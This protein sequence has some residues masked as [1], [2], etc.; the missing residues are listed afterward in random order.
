MNQMDTKRRAAIVAALVEGFG[1]RSTC[2]M[3]STSKGAALKLVADLGAACANYHDREVRGIACNFL[4]IDE[5]WAF[6]YAKSKN[7]PASK[8]DEFGYG[9]V[10][11]WTAIDAETKLI[12]SWL[13]GL[14][15]GGYATELMQDLAGRLVNRP[16]IT[17]DGLASYPA[18]IEEAFGQ[19]VDYAQLQKIYGPNP[20]GP[21]RRYSPA[22]C[23]GARVEVISGDPA[24]DQ[25]S[26]SYVERS[27]LSIR[28]G[29]RRFTRLTNG[30]SKKVEN[31]C[32]ALAIYVMHYNF[33][34]LHESLR[35]KKNNRRTPAMAAGLA[36]RP[37]TLAELV[38]ILP[39][40]V[41]KKRGP[42]RPRNSK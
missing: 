6:C 31:H 39:P 13:V 37:W 12:P 19:N 3:T 28:M 9:D 7:V 16:Q 29:L 26:T 33:C 15:D 5:I 14:R 20:E 25:V 11:T 38:E 35:T 27:N 40:P 21:E 42:Y 4:Q 23:I 1:I 24:P 32:A 17:T 30:H 8:R 22:E 18:A 2:R 10:W 34:R 41:P 36:E